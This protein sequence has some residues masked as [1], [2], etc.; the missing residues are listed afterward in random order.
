VENPTRKLKPEMYATVT[1]GVP[2]VEAL[3]VPLTAILRLADQ[4]VVF[5]E[6]GATPDGRRRFVRRVVAAGDDEGT[7]LVPVTH[8]LQPG[9]KVVTS[10][11]I[12]LSG[13]L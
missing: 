3:A 10:G 2:G 5:V 12:L 7:S 11:A 1:I 4:T 8:G 6:Q 13:M 9:E